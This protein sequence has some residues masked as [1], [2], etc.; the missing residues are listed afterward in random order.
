MRWMSHHLLGLEHF[1]KNTTDKLQKLS[2]PKRQTK[3]IFGDIFETLYNCKDQ[4]EFDSELEKLR[5][6][7]IE[8]EVRY[9]RNEPPSQFL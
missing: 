8:I 4:Q 2:F 3:I 1:R 5:D 9:T 7:W 6:T